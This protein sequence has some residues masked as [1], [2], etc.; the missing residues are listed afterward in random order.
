MSN[1]LA[2]PFVSISVVSGTNEDWI[3]SIKFVVDDGITPVEDMPQL[4]LS[5]IEFNMEVRLRPDD[6]DVVI[7]ASTTDGSL[8][9]GEPPNFGFLLIQVPYERMK[10]QPPGS[11]VADIVGKDNITTRRVVA[12]ALDLAEGITR[13]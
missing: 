3:D 13:P 9:I 7:R 6:H 1:L 2:M 11:Y 12:I 10:Q 5:G 4:D 8:A